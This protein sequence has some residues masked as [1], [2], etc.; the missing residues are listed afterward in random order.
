MFIIHRLTPGKK[1][2]RRNIFFHPVTRH[3]SPVTSKSLLS[4]LD[5]KIDRLADISANPVN[6]CSR[7]E[8]FQIHF[9]IGSRRDQIAVFVKQFKDDLLVAAVLIDLGIEGRTSDLKSDLDHRL[10]RIDRTRIPLIKSSAGI[11]MSWRGRFRC[12]WR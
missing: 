12:R 5:R 9:L 7:R 2:G 1:T 11:G 6:V 8:I 3:L 4:A 10:R